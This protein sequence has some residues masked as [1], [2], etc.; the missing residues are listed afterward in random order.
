MDPA[1]DHVRPL[2]NVVPA[3]I[4]DAACNTSTAHSELA[5]TRMNE[6]VTA[7]QPHAD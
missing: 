5:K 7:S 4:K 2:G 6:V 3:E 1:G